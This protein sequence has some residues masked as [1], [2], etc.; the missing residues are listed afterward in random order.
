MK[1]LIVKK[2]VIEGNSNYKQ[3]VKTTWYFIGIPIFKSFR[4]INQ[5][6]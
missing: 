3:T 5:C 1:A 2:T 6:V 4:L